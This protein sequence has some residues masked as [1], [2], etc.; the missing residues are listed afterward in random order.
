MKRKDFTVNV[1]WNSGFR[2]VNDYSPAQIVRLI[3][4]DL[5][6]LKRVVVPMSP[7]TYGSRTAEELW[8]DTETLGWQLVAKA[9]PETNGR[10]NS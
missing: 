1:L 2:V 8:I 3:K 9:M 6:P 10:E 7:T 5:R 4:D